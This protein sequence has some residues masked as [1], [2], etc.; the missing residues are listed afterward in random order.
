MSEAAV[1]ALACKA[2]AGSGCPDVQPA[3]RLTAIAT[4]GGFLF[5]YDTAVISGAIRRARCQ[6]HHA[7]H[8]D[9]I[10][11][12]SLSGWMVSCALLGA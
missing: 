12:S 8:L 3:G 2:G 4:L 9:E 10:A 11:G 7:R 6:L 1:G 5:G